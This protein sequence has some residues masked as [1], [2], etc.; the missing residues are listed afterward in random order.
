MRTFKS[1]G[2][3]AINASSFTDNVNLLVSTFADY[4]YRMADTTRI[5]RGESRQIHAMVFQKLQ[6]EILKLT[7]GELVDVVYLLTEFSRG[8]GQSKTIS[9]DLCTREL[10]QLKQTAISILIKRD[11]VS[12]D[13]KNKLYEKIG[14]LLA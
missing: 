2:D 1:E 13:L 12:E 11:N 3:S 8:G 14:L 10:K 5:S 9:A 7:D 6:S 4:K